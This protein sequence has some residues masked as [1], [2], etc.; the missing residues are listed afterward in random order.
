M[1]VNFSPDE[2]LK[3]AE[4]MERNGNSFYSSAAKSSTRQITR[5]LLNRLADMEVEH[6][7][8]FAGMRN[9][10]LSLGESTSVYDPE[11]HA[12]LYLQAWADGQVF[13]EKG[14]L[15]EQLIGNIDIEEILQTAIGLEKDSILFYI[16]MKEMITEER[17]R[18]EIDVIINEEMKHIALL[19]SELRSLRS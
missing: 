8:V 15:T 2:I 17:G 3:I 4:Q 10:L 6:E 18:S 12:I 7:K 14:N 19:S 9:K 5:D 11:D 1:I 16:G 13:D